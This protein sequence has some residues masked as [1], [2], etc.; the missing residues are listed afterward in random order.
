[1]RKNI[2][3]FD[4]EEMS[5]KI[6]KERL[7][8][9][10]KEPI[11]VDDVID[12]LLGNNDKLKYITRII[13]GPYDIDKLDYVSRDAY[14]TGEVEYG[15]I[16][17]IRIIDGFRVLDV[18]LL[19]SSKTLNF[20]MN[21]FTATQYMYF[22]VYYHKTSRIFDFML[23]EA[24]KMMP[25]CINEII[26]NIDLFLEIDD[27]NFINYVKKRINKTDANNNYKESYEIL[28][29]IRN[30]KKKYKNIYQFQLTL[31]V[32]SC[33]EE[34]LDSLKKTLEEEYKD[35]NVKVD[36]SAKV[37]PIRVDTKV[38]YEWME[39][40]MIYDENTHKAIN[41]FNVSLA[42][43]EFLKKLQ[44]LFYIYIDDKIASDERYK[45]RI[46]DLCDVAK[47]RLIRIQ[48]V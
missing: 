4:H 28:K 21:C 47:D 37:K 10:V 35:L 2:K 22:N 16:D 1:M 24:M 32:S 8:D 45:K 43:Y 14:H 20:I 12:I 17:Y 26:N 41:L 46:N 44:L 39:E 23:F 5:A 19:I 36:Y 6:I 18:E 42:S 30:R 11:N 13:D 34:R 27:Y 48:R 9:K 38:F 33:K 3:I 15:G 40:D 25:D 29:N 7:N 31:D